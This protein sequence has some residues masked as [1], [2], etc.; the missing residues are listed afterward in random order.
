M[1]IKFSKKAY[2]YLKKQNTKTAQRILLA[3]EGLRD[4]PFKGDIE[5]M[6]GREELR[7]RVGN[8]RVTFE[9]KDGE[10]HILRI[11][12]RGDIYKK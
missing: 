5:T 10:I 11:G 7:L 1:R 2:K 9:E 8:L 12:P 3:I 4:K 6:E